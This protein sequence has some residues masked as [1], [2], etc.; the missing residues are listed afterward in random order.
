LL[1]IKDRVEALGGHINLH[2]PRGA[3]TDLRVTLLRSPKPTATHPATRML[4]QQQLGSPPMD[5]RLNAARGIAV[6]RDDRQV[7]EISVA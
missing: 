1:G 5:G 3:G 4:N 2:S 7:H 6:S